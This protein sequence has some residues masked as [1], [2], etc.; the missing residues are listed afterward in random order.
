VIRTAAIKRS[1][2]GLRRSS[3][4]S[5]PVCTAGWNT[6]LPLANMPPNC[7]VILENWF[8]RPYEV[9]TRPGAQ[10]WVQ[11]A[12]EALSTFA[13]WNGPGSSK[14]FAAGTTGLW[15][16]TTSNPTPPA[17]L[18]P[19]AS[20]NISSAEISTIGGHFLTIVNGID[21]LRLF[22]GAAWQVITGASVPAITG[23]PTTS[24]RTVELLKRRL[25][26]SV[27]SSSSAY[28]LPTAQIAGVLTEFPLGQVFRRGGSLIAMAPWTIDGGSG[29]DDL[30]VFVSS[31]GEVAVYRGSDPA[32]DFSLVGVYYIGEPV[33]R[34]PLT[35]Y[36]GDLLFLCR[37][38]LYPLS[39]ALLSATINRQTALTAN[40][41]PS[42]AEATSLYGGNPN[43]R[44]CL[45]PEGNLLLVSIP[46]TPDYSVQFVMNTLTGAW[47]K[48][49]GWNAQDWVVFNL[50]LLFLTG[51]SVAQAWAGT[52]DFGASIDCR[53]QQAFS[54]FGQKGRN[55]HFKLLRPT[56]S[57]TDQANIFIGLDTDLAISDFAATE[58]FTSTLGSRWN[59][60]N[61]DAAIWAGGR[62]AQRDWATIAT[63]EGF[64]YSLRL[65]V[66]SNTTTLAW[67]STD[68]VYELGGIL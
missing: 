4:L 56:I 20:S 57:S 65:Q 36:G 7:A 12:P 25:W 64:S 18:F 40:I 13:V 44:V 30:T 48:F 11:T 60:D 19:L 62:V 27:N 6:Q 15:D 42:F 3:T 10:Y 63:R 1:T 16:A 24:L 33:G 38:G 9:E 47:C 46:I 61:W 45:F 51:V 26:F 68:V 32:T 2:A 34:F 59:M 35:K 53:C 31:L 21:S 5:L 43:W 67:S 28:Y 49:T 55:K 22:D 23:V 66:S 54:Y 39:K 50:K 58:I 8:P 29:S 41:A 37:D 17:Q 52:S 14:L